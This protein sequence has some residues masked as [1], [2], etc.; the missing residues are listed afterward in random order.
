MQ[1]RSVRIF[2]SST[3]R[4]YGEERDLLVR[5]V[6]PNLRAKLK[7]RFVEL[8]DVDLRWGITAAQAERGEVLPICL[9]E[10]DRARPF[11]VGMLGDRYGWVPP[12]DAYAPDLVERQPWLDSHRGGKS[13][14]ELEMLH[15][16]LNNPK[17][18]GRALFYFRSSS[19][20]KQKGGDYLPESPADHERQQKLKARISKHRFPVVRYQNPEAFAKRLEK[21][22]WKLL[23]KE[24]PAT[25]VPDAYTREGLKHEAY[26]APRRRL[27][28][29]G[30]KYLQAL[31][32]AITKKQTKILIEGGSGGGK[33]A[34]LANWLQSYQAKHPEHLVFEYYLGASTDSADPA[35]LVRRLIETIKRI[36]GSNDE[37]AGVPQLLDDSITTWLAT[38]SSSA[39]KR[40][41]SWVL[42]LDSLNS[43]TDLKDLRWLPDFLPPHITLIVSTLPGEVK[44]ALLTKVSN[45]VSTKASKR[46]SSAKKE[47]WHTLQVKPLT[48]TQRKNL[49]VTYLAKYNKTLAPDL[50]KQALAHPLANN[51]LFIRTL[52]EELRLFGVHEELQR[53][54]KQYLSSKTI[55]DL[56]ERVLKR[57]EGDS[58]KQAVQM[59]MQSIWASRAGLTEKE[60]LAI[61]NLKPATWAPIRNALDEC[62]L[63]SNGKIAFAHDYMRIAVKDRY[64]K[65]KQ[66]QKQA[67]INLA[68]YFQKQTADARRA[69]EEPY[70]WREAQEWESLKRCLVD[71]QLF[72]DLTNDNHQDQ[73]EKYWIELEK[74]NKVNIQN[75]YQRVWDL[76]RNSVNPD[77]LLKILFRL[78]RFLRNK[79]FLSEFTEGL[80]RQ[81]VSISSTLYGTKSKEYLLSLHQL[82]VLLSEKM[83]FIEAEHTFKECLAREKRYSRSRGASINGL[84]WIL[85]NTNRATEA[86]NLYEDLLLNL[87]KVGEAKSIDY[88]N[89]LNN[90][91]ICLSDMNLKREAIAAIAKS[92]PITRAILGKNSAT[93]AIRIGNIGTFLRESKHPRFALKAHRRELAILH[94]LY[95]DFHIDVAVAYNNFALCLEDL[96]KY[97][98]AELYYRKAIAIQE[99]YGGDNFTVRKDYLNNLASL[100]DDRDRGS[101]ASDLYRKILYLYKKND[102]QE[103]VDYAYFLN[104]IGV[105]L[106]LEKDNKDEALKY[107]IPALKIRKSHLLLNHELTQVSYHNLAMLLMAIG[108]YRASIKLRKEQIRALK[109]S[110]LKDFLEIGWALNNLGCAYKNAGDK[111]LAIK[112]FTKGLE[113]SKMLSDSGK[114]LHDSCTAWIRLVQTSNE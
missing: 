1:N 10:I 108:D 62:F 59:A 63:E 54:L 16:V 110:E 47:Q 25:S 87:E 19:Y 86:K 106:F 112:A 113:Y 96:R 100:L 51:P 11:F 78:E 41:T 60:I 24:F 43:L 55:D 72:L 92:M 34:L 95:S 83:N 53:R 68:K 31:T 49:L 3:F 81:S 39:G 94:S 102:R 69:E 107:L 74:K 66:L 70:Q 91:A 23:D 38:G 8:V 2:L 37:I 44:E 109:T 22:L 111:R 93:E 28:L 45:A 88:S 33:S 9:A 18:A 42:A 4:D 105:H 29:G 77:N 26:A 6:F 82:G 35:V 52:A 30:E 99:K 84:A 71:Y 80:A 101:E 12:K 64:L 97:S 61:V 75:E 13:V 21:D 50:I 14:T 20:A 58:G 48:S 57:V 114:E 98:K 15:G 65:T 104:E 79:G 27:Y 40:K 46:P 73:L 76:W 56:F 103:D 89:T 85:R 90:Y 32:A 17:M 5:K 7:D 67:H 36:T